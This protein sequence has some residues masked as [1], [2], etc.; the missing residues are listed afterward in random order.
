MNLPCFSPA[1]CA[2]SDIFPSS[3]EPFDPGSEPAPLNRI[4]RD[5]DLLPYPNSYVRAVWVI[6]KYTGS[7]L[8]QTF[9]YFLREGKARVV[10]CTHFISRE[11]L[12]DFSLF[13]SI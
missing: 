4:L 6:S 3:L 10:I 11:Q 7:A 9:L 13:D 5:Y 1:G 8:V 12:L 2:P